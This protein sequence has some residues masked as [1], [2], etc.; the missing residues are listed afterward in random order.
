[1]EKGLDSYKLKLIALVFMILDHVH[2]YLFRSQPEFISLITRFV[3]PLF[4]YLMIDGFYHTKSRKKFLI[5]LFVT[6]IIMQLGNTIIN[7]VFHYL[8][9]QKYDFYLPWNNIF[10]TLA[11]MFAFVWCLENVRQ[12]NRII[13]NI[14]LALIT[15]ISS[16]FCEGGIYLLPIAFVIWFF[17]EKRHLQFAGISVWCIIILVYELSYYFT[18]KPCDIYHYL[19]FNNEWAMIKIIHK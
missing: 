13:L 4:L 15:A 11:C 2:T 5:R 18:A 7:E 16:I 9:P 19:C 8:N 10:L 1:M 6:G 14:F 17:H 12:R 3:S